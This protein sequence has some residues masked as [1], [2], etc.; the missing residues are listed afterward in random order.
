MKPDSFF[1]LFAAVRVMRAAFSDAFKIVRSYRATYALESEMTPDALVA[2]NAA[3]A[4][5][6]DAVV[7]LDKATQQIDVV[8]KT[9]KE[10][11]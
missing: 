2:F 4:A 3:F 7:A 8:Y 10:P 11:R 9:M 6:D 5:L 1:N